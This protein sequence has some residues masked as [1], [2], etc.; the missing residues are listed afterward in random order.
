MSEKGCGLSLDSNLR[1]RLEEESIRVQAKGGTLPF[2]L[3][4]GGK[5][6]HSVTRTPPGRRRSSPGLQNV[7]CF[8]TSTTNTQGD[9]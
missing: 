5:T 2:S 7:K 1:E 4:S 6:N 8:I 9:V 3:W